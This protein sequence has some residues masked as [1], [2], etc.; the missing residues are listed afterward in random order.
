[1]KFILLG[2]ANARFSLSCISIEDPHR[3]R[4]EIRIVQFIYYLKRIGDFLLPFVKFKVVTAI[5]TTWPAK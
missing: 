1:M 3:G 4:L 5:S 2:L